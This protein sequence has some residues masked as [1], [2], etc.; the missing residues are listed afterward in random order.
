MELA[1]AMVLP[2][3][4]RAIISLT[5]LRIT[6]APTLAVRIEHV[7]VLALVYNCVAKK[8]LAIVRVCKVSLRKLTPMV[9]RR[10]G[11]MHR[12]VISLIGILIKNAS[13]YDHVSSGRTTHDS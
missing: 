9:S 5:I 6:S 3:P 12:Q 11:E 8:K 4:T 13:V 7:P 1:V 2:L 10:V